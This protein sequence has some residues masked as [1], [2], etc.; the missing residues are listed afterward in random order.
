ML[1]SE[2]KLENNSW[3]N[4]SA[5]IAVLSVMQITAEANLEK[6]VD[7]M[8]SEKRQSRVD[9]LEGRVNYLQGE[10]DALAR[11]A[12]TL[13][14]HFSKTDSLMEAAENVLRSI[15]ISPTGKHHFLMSDVEKITALRS[16]VERS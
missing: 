15:Q 14:Q 8:N 6:T 3:E 13:Q 9:F 12:D 16:I 7:A 5:V 4:P 11:I 10:K 2:M 1:F